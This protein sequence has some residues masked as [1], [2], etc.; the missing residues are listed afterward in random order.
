MSSIRKAVIP[1]AGL[2][3]RMQ[4]L[5]RVIPKEMLPLGRKP[6]LQFIVE[7]LQ[8]GGI[9][10]I[11]IVTREDKPTIQ[12]Y[13][14]SWKGVDFIQEN[15]SR[16]LGYAVLMAKEFVGEENFAV[17]L[18]DALIGGEKP[19][20]FVSDLIRRHVELVAALTMAIYQVPIK[21]T[22]LRGI[23]D[24]VGEITPGEPVKIQDMREKPDSE[25]APSTWAGVGRYIF[26]PTIFDALEDSPSDPQG[27]YQLT[28][29]IRLLIRSGKP[30]YGFPLYPGQIRFDTG[31]LAGYIK[32]FKYFM[33]NG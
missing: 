8:A 7:E 16:G 14:G 31:N 5:T 22:H 32:A 25:S 6:I 17:A 9:E 21:E 30:A 18:A 29:G 13:F 23:V 27:E 20:E 4:P 11:L 3:K 26:S 19:T 1:A 2:G 28:D 10:E 33:T 24:P 15:H 12:R